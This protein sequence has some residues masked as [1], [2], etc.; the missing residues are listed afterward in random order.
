MSTTISELIAKKKAELDSAAGNPSSYTAEAPRVEE[1]STPVPPL[2]MIDV[3]K[4]PVLKNSIR[5]SEIVGDSLPDGSDPVY[6]RSVFA[7][8]H[9]DIPAPDPLWV[10]DHNTLPYTIA[11]IMYGHNGLIVGPPGTGKTKDVREICARAKIPYYRVN[12]MDGMEF[13]DLAGSVHLVDGDTK[14]ID[15]PIVTPIETGGVLAVDEP[16]K[17]PAGTLMGLQALAEE[18]NVDRYIMRA[19]HEDESKVKLSAHPEFRM[20]LCDNVRGTGDG[21]DR[22]AATQIQD[23]SFINRMT[24][25][26]LKDYMPPATERKAITAAYPWVSDKLAG[27]MVQLANLMR[28]AWSNGSVDLPFSFRELQGWS[29]A[30]AETQ[31]IRQSL[32]LVYGNLLTEDNEKEI[33]T[34]AWNDVGN[35]S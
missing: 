23:Q 11:C 4:L 15:G 30:I 26:I 28:K 33:L 24:Y 18:G 9:E 17:M 6:P 3:S 29:S 16:F 21:A 12:G 1:E 14:F 2:P 13:S 20:I 10:P 35:W 32:E 8:D 27:S 5:Y 34:N 19:G 31:D 22:M 25:K 7:E